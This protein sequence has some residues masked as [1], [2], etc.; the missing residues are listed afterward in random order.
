V[1]LYRGQ[2]LALM[3]VAFTAL[4]VALFF[5][6]WVGMERI[7]DLLSL[8]TLAASGLCIIVGLTSAAMSYVYWVP[9]WERV[10]KRTGSFPGER[11]K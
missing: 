1:I 7:G 2:I 8:G 6:F 5:T 3:A 11:R 9:K 4:G 10:E